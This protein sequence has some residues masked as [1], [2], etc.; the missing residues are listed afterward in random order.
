PAPPP[1]TPITARALPESTETTAA[2]VECDRLPEGILLISEKT[3]E[4]YPSNGAANARIA[5]TNLTIDSMLFRPINLDIGL[6]YFTNDGT[7]LAM[8]VA[9][10]EIRPGRN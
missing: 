1:I 3:E 5:L 4:H 2:P 10:Q 9:Q 8:Y 6:T 7:P